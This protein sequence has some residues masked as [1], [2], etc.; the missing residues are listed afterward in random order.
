MRQRCARRRRAG[1]SLDLGAAKRKSPQDSRY[2]LPSAPHRS[3]HNS[4]EQ[5][6]SS[7]WGVSEQT[8]TFGAAAPAREEP[9]VRRPPP[10]PRS[11]QRAPR[12]YPLPRT[13]RIKH[14]TMASEAA[15]P[16]IPGAIVTDDELPPIT[17]APEAPPEA[18]QTIEASSLER[19]SL[20]EASG[21]STMVRVPEPRS[22]FPGAFL[23]RPSRWN[24]NAAKLVVPRD[25]SSRRS[26]RSRTACERRRT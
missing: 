2:R 5:G 20:P 17:P 6:T 11:N 21:A 13:H 4:L 26:T 7:H 16:T 14:N 18:P 22:L 3:E 15:P 23:R 9:F 10:S 19:T 1:G 12:S 25:S 8:S 24:R